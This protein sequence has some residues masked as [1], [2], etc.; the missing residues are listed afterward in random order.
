VL[1][2]FK[3]NARLGPPPPRV[4]IIERRGSMQTKDGNWPCWDNDCQATG[5]IDPVTPLKLTPF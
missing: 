2:T 3:W 1:G 4:N 5:E